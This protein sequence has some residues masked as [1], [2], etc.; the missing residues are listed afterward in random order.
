METQQCTFKP[1]INKAC[2]GSTKSR[3]ASQSP[4][5]ESQEVH[6]RLYE[7]SQKSQNRLNKLRLQKSEQEAAT[8]SFTPQ[9]VVS[10]KIEKKYKQDSRESSAQRAARLYNSWATRNEK[11]DTERRKQEAE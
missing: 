1:T 5:E 7:K 11:I 10:K 6:T 2:T 3:E 9:R 8:Y 4:T